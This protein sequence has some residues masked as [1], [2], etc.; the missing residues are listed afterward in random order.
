MVFGDKAIS[1]DISD[2]RAIFG[3]ISSEGRFPISGVMDPTRFEKSMGSAKR[4][5]ESRSSP[6]SLEECIGSPSQIGKLGRSCWAHISYIRCKV[7]KRWLN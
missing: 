7:S 1:D 3:N 6:K 4:S 2:E 5:R